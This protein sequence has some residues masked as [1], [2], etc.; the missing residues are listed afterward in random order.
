MVKRKSRLR[1]KTGLRVRIR[2]YI[3]NRQKANGG[4]NFKPELGR[5]TKEGGDGGSS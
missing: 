2:P 1:R 3:G 4:K 5:K